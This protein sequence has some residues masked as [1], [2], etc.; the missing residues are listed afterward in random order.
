[1]KTKIAT[2]KSNTKNVTLDFKKYSGI[3]AAIINLGIKITNDK[4]TK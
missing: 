3:D 2:T 4:S 1:M